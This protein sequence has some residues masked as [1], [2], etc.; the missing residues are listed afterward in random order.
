[1]PWAYLKANTQQER[2]RK[3]FLL[4]LICS[5][6]KKQRRFCINYVKYYEF[7]CR[8]TYMFHQ[9]VFCRKICKSYYYRLYS[10]RKIYKTNF[11]TP[12]LYIYCISYNILFK[13]SNVLYLSNNFFNSKKTHVHEKTTQNFGLFYFCKMVE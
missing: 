4:Y 3:I 13:K 9:L 7:L 10:S 5:C 2:H 8:W 12:N 6:V 11:N 1:M